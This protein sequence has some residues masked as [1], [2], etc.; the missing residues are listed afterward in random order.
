M[1]LQARVCLEKEAERLMIYSRLRTYSFVLAIIAVIATQIG[2]APLTAQ[3]LRS[4]E[5]RKQVLKV[6]EP[7]QAVFQRL[8][9]QVRQCYFTSRMKS[10]STVTAS[11]DNHSRVASIELTRLYGA[12]GSRVSML[13]DVTALA[14]NQTEVSIYAT[15]PYRSDARQVA[16]WAKPGKLSCL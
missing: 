14:E 11:K 16:R 10:Q 9:K 3:D 8:A 15:Y 1:S 6:D 12:D 5:V 7:Y 2:C 4:G 13:V